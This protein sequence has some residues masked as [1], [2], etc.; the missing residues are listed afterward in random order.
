MAEEEAE[1]SIP[2]P[3]GIRYCKAYQGLRRPGRPACSSAR[4][5]CP[6]GA[7]KCFQCGK[8]GHGKGDCTT[9]D[10]PPDPVPS[11]KRPFTAST[12]T[13]VAM[14]GAKR[15]SAIGK[16]VCPDG[17]M[18]EVADNI[19]YCKAYQGL[20]RLGRPACP[21]ARKVCTN[22]AHKCSG[23]G[24]KGHGKGDCRTFGPPP[25]LSLIHI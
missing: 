24:Q 14:P 5:V 17:L 11:G 25:D 10:P 3:D 21:S 13:S 18:A 22:G 15:F 7:H 20:R 19:R 16:D 2:G 1:K 12:S 9:Y 23:C 6:N 4:R 8:K